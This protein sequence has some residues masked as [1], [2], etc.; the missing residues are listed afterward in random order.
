MTVLWRKGQDGGDL[1]ME[2]P[3]KLG[4]LGQ[5]YGGNAVKAVV[6]PPPLTRE[7]LALTKS[8]KLGGNYVDR[9]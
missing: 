7:A 4:A 8:R 9:Q 1:C 3:A 5:F 6:V 2:R